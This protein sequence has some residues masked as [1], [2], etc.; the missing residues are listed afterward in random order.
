[1]TEGPRVTL[2]GQVLAGKY[3]VDRLIGEG[4][5]GYVLAAHHLELDELVAIKCTRSELANNADLTE[6]FLREARLAVK[7][8]SEH[9]VR[10]HDIGRTAE[11]VPFIVMEFL[12]GHD[13]SSV[14]EKG[15][16]L[17]VGQTV[18]YILQACEAIG[19][20]HALGIVHRD[21]KPQNLF[22]AK[23]KDGSEVIKVLDFGISKAASDKHSMTQTGAMLGSPLY[24]SPEQMR[25]SREAEPR[26]DIWS[27]GIILFELLTGE[28]PFTGESLP[29]LCLAVVNKDTPSLRQLAPAVPAELESVVKRCLAKTPE[30]RPA[31]I[32]ELIELLAP[33]G[34]RQGVTFGRTHPGWTSGASA[35]GPAKSG[36]SPAV[37]AGV[38]VGAL[39]LVGGIAA[40][41]VRGGHP[42]PV[43]PA[44]PPPSAVVSV[45][46]PPAPSAP[47]APSSADPPVTISAPSASATASSHVHHSHARNVPSASVAPSVVPPPPPAPVT[48]PKDFEGRR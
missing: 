33:F 25:S 34:K 42:A 27:L 13:L 20:A 26:S 43:A 8:K 21:L 35:K 6:R 40:F 37:K 1:M 9:V 48:K 39:A 11:G 19:E 45:E 3:R 5:M 12:E 10:V 47:P 4:G 24:M 16:L 36:R 7:I 46:T 15:A 2:V 14:T 17:E 30:K 23:R 31:N 41:M 32:A 29:E 22:L 38:A 18:D 28:V 44:T